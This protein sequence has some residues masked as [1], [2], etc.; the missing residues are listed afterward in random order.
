MNKQYLLWI[1]IMWRF[2]CSDSEGHKPWV[3]NL[4]GVSLPHVRPSP[5]WPRPVWYPT[6]RILPRGGRVYDGG[7]R[8]DPW[9]GLDLA[10]ERTEVKKTQT[11]LSLY[12][13]VSINFLISW[14]FWQGIK[15]VWKLKIHKRGLRCI[16][17]F[18]LFTLV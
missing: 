17:K 3:V 5:V 18:S 10:T 15:F 16:R 14:A 13:R 2:E 8:D 12:N 11:N 4:R 6:L 9:R 1:C 7:I